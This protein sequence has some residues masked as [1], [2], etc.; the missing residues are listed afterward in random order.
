MDLQ[1]NLAMAPAAFLAY[2]LKEDADGMTALDNL[3]ETLGECES[4]YASECGQFGDAGP[5]QAS[6]ISEM[7]A[8]LAAVKARIAQLKGAQP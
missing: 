7:R 6:A 3:S 5:G 1:K 2:W 4:Q 8:E